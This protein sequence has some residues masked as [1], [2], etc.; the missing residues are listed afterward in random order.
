MSDLYRNP[1]D[2]PSRPEEHEAPQNDAQDWPFE[3]A[4]PGGKTT[5]IE[6]DER[7]ILDT[8]VFRALGR[9][10]QAELGSSHDGH[11]QGIY[12]DQGEK[13]GD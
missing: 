8:V 2:G 4:G 1:Q 12:R 13:Y 7:G 11:A 9:H 10:K 5:L 6:N 3:I